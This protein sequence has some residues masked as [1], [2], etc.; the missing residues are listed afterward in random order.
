MPGDI[1]LR[2]GTLTTE[3]LRRLDPHETVDKTLGVYLAM[4]GNNSREIEHLK[5]EVQRFCETVRTQKIE[6]NDAWYIFEHSIMK[7]LEYPLAALTLN[8]SEWDSIMKPLLK[9]IL[10]KAGFA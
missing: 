7:T 3:T 8:Y 10:P 9:I 2:T 1:N 4:D 6:C 5:T